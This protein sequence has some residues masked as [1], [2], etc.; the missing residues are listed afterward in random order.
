MGIVHG[1]NLHG[2]YAIDVLNGS[3]SEDATLWWLTVSVALPIFLVDSAWRLRL[4]HGGADAKCVMWVAILIPNW[5]A[6]PV[7]FPKE[8]LISLPPS[9]AL[10]MWGGVTFLLLPILF[11]I[12]N[13]MR[14][15]GPFR[16]LWHAYKMDLEQAMKKHVWILTTIVDMPSGEKRI[17]HKT[18]APSRTPTQ[19]ELEYLVEE[20]RNND[21]ETVWVTPKLPL[22]VFLWPAIIPLIIVGGPMAFIMPL[23]GI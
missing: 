18:R 23:L 9:I 20:L 17:V 4:I 2:E 15:G 19:K 7:Y 13:F 14:G 1:A 10:L 21:V 3:A 22:L 6:V 5:G 12:F 11:V 16:L 8:S